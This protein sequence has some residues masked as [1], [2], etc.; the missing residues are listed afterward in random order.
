[1]KVFIFSP[2]LLLLSNR[3][4]L[5]AEYGLHP[6]CLAGLCLCGTECRA[7]RWDQSC[8]P[9][10]GGHAEHI[11]GPGRAC[12]GAG[13]CREGWG[14]G[15]NEMCYPL[16][17]RTSSPRPDWTTAIVTI[18]RPDPEHPTTDM[19]ISS[20]LTYGPTVSA[21]P[22]G[23]PLS[24][25]TTT[26]P[27]SGPGHSSKTE[28]KTARL[29][30]HSTSHAPSSQ[31]SFQAPEGSTGTLPPTPRGDSSD[32]TSRNAGESSEPPSKDTTAR[33][34]DSTAL[35][36]TAASGHTDKD[37]GLATPTII[38]SP[39]SQESTILSLEST[40]MPIPA[41]V[42]DLNN[43][44][45]SILPPGGTEIEFPTVITNTDGQHSTHSSPD[46]I[47][48][49]P[50]T[51]SVI[52]GSEGELSTVFPSTGQNDISSA[53]PTMIT[54]SDGQISTILPKTADKQDSTTPIIVTGP[55]A[56][57]STNGSP[58]GIESNTAIPTA[59]T[60]SNG[61]VTTVVPPVTESSP[62]VETGTDTLSGIVTT[63]SDGG[64]VSTILPT[65]TATSYESSD[66]TEP[67]TSAQ[68]TTTSQTG[69]EKTITTETTQPET[70]G[71][72]AKEAAENTET[73]TTG[74]N[75]FVSSGISDVTGTTSRSETTAAS[76]K[77]AVTSEE[78]SRAETTGSETAIDLTTAQST[79]SDTG[80]TA[81]GTTE[82]DATVTEPTESETATTETTESDVPSNDTTATN[83]TGSDLTAIETTGTD[84][85]SLSTS[86]ST[87]SNTLSSEEMAGSVTTVSTGTESVATS[88][89]APMDTPASTTA[90]SQTDSSETTRTVSNEVVTKTEKE[91]IDPVDNATT[92]VAKVTTRDGDD[93]DNQLPST[94][95]GDST[96]TS[97]DYVITAV[98]TT[99]T[100]PKPT[101]DGF[102]IPC[103][104]WFFDAC[105]GPILGWMVIR[106]PGV[107]PPGP[108]PSISV[109]PGSGIEINTK[110]PLP[111]WPEY[112][113]GPKQSPTF[114][115][116]PT[117][118]ETESAELCVTST[119][120]SV[121][122]DA[123]MT[124]TVTSDVTSICGTVYGCKVQDVD[125][126]A[127][128]TVTSTASTPEGTLLLGK[129]QWPDTSES[130]EDLDAA[131]DHA[132]SELDKVFG[133]RTPSRTT[134][135]SPSSTSS[136]VESTTSTSE[137][138]SSSSDTVTDMPTLTQDLPEPTI[139]TPEGYSCAETDTHTQCAMGPGGQQACIERTSCA[140]WVTTTTE[141]S[142]ETSTTE[143]PTP[144]L[145]TPDHSK[146]RKHCYDSGQKS[147]YGSIEAAAESFCHNVIDDDEQGSVRSNYRREG[148]KQPAHGY[149]FILSFE[150]YEGCGWKA[151]YDECMRY[152]RVPID[153]CDC[154]AKGNKQGGWVDNN[155][156]K[157]MIDPRHGS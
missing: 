50:A 60:D 72:E 59:M 49:S 42:T 66:T 113:V 141:E 20:I 135:F 65:E 36:D 127:T 111:S 46:N 132:Q 12:C 63:N 94:K 120:Y 54:D 2:V 148:K 90:I 104:L 87:E 70:T 147:N 23:E 35:T 143:S 38:T 109:P 5:A 155:C 89:T 68:K 48:S 4:A 30:P 136:T 21:T 24:S 129:E 151:N 61:Q 138:S 156:I 144:T 69:E 6:E 31:T 128:A 28:G 37:T 99:V 83:I 33:N 19:E 125:H 39:N 32:R 153:S 140:S 85:K 34:M 114:S 119:S 15:D 88:T 112:T 29:D 86:Q 126:S 106:P 101:D 13:C 116:E 150:V 84:S 133:P 78:A 142:E 11:C 95:T 43:S 139:S 41:T 79:G 67:A 58:T 157:A 73:Q 117:E 98:T 62:T 91:A 93:D 97:D 16:V 107:Y 115:E 121:S 25:E 17:T 57:E 40:E 105:I 47:E 71:T 80:T 103:S 123:T 56:E 75:S 131:A 137:E 81:T 8:C 51:S 53:I 154:S 96:P 130:D 52:T 45:S 122:V 26:F 3:L 100:K 134:T 102:V 64:Q 82:L 77:T 14:C 76:E 22:S 9:K 118:C 27:R 145:K 55:N 124:N 74:G 18:V 152:M 146:N 110:G 7:I 10:E 44:A 108:P 1:M 149:H 92:E